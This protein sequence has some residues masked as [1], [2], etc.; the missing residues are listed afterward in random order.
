MFQNSLLPVLATTLVLTLGACARV[1]PGQEGD[2]RPFTF[3][4]IA[5]PQVGMYQAMEE[6]V[7]DFSNEERDLARAVA[8]VAELQPDFIV[9]GGD[10]VS[11]WDNEDQIAVFMDFQAQ[12]EEHAPVHVLPGNHDQ[13]P[14]RRALDLYRNLHGEDYYR[15]GFRGTEMIVI[16]SNYF[17]YPN[18]EMPEEV[19][20]H[21]EW[22]E[23][24]LAT[25]AAREPDHLF[26]LSHHPFFIEDPDEA[27]NYFNIEP[28]T[29]ARCLALFAEHG[30]DAIFTGH[31]HREARGFAGGI[32]HIV[33]SS[34][35]RPLGDDPP[36]LRLVTVTPD[37]FTHEYLPL[38]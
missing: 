15:L 25:A 1:I 26:I 2:I 22:L 18:D 33:T 10:M 23:Q 28:E 34:L 30:V 27:D 17:A 4:F 14:V 29:R 16:N 6:E 9:I 21:W 11:R 38:P 8:L 3:A 31:L 24:E 36:G 35:G 20:A 12:L 32:E 37:S 5:D 13:P 7:D 19:T